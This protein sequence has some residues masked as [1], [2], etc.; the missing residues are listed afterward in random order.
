MTTEENARQELVKE[1][2]ALG[3]FITTHAD[4]IEKE[5]LVETDSLRYPIIDRHIDKKLR[6]LSFNYWNNSIEHKL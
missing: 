2:R 4:K 5:G 6:D 1:L 3:A